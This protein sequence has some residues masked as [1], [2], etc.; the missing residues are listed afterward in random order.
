[1][2]RSIKWLLLLIALLLSPLFAPGVHAQTINAASC[3]ES[4]VASALA[5]INTDGTTVVVPLGDCV[6]TTALSYTQTNSF[7]LQG[8]GAISGTGVQASV[9]G[10]GTDL[11]TLE[12]NVQANACMLCITTLSGKSFRM[13]GFHIKYD[14]ANGVVSDSAGVILLAGQSSSV[15]FDH[16]HVDQLNNVDLYLA[17]GIE[18]VVDHN[19]FDAGFGDENQI[20]CTDP[21]WNGA[22]DGLGNASWAD[23]SHFGTSQF[24]YIETNN[25]RWANGTPGEG[26][27]HAFMVDIGLDGGR[28]VLRDN[29]VGLHVGIQT[30]ATSG[31]TQDHRGLRAYEIYNNTFV[32]S[33]NPT[34]DQFSFLVQL[35]GGT[36]LWWGNTIT[37]F[38]TFISGQDVR[39][40]NSTYAETVTPNGWGYCGTAETGIGSKWDGSAT[41]T[42]YPCLDQIG[43]GKGDLLKGDFPNK[44]DSVTNT[45]QWPNQVLEP[46]YAWDNTFNPVPQEPANY[47]TNT[48]GIQENRDYY[49]QLPNANE[50]ATFNGTAG[51][52]QGLASAKPS[53]CT[54]SV[55]WWATDT[56]TL[57][58][59]ATSN[60]WTAYYTPFTYPHPLTLGQTSGQ[61]SG[62]PAAPTNLA[63]VVQ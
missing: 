49:L 9:T 39:T 52:G 45:I 51:I 32:W 25:F 35:E 61:T 43:R 13:T 60:T 16:N 8:A 22:V 36:G 30:H 46:V 50:S 15:R 42:G 10:T 56:Q 12:D 23:S 40:T 17:G 57:Y 29:A 53:T 26:G 62:N 54:P 18:G 28:C 7:T 38:N 11:T 14:S 47:F 4:A 3:S 6:W 34:T 24:M 31:G 5:S 41:G 21:E 44:V 37:G 2:I 59:C 33:S 48:T 1:M 63:A 19:Q 58:Q 55:G 27:V 20:R